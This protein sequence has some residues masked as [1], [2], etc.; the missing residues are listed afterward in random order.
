[1]GFNYKQD[2][3]NQRITH[4]LV[5]EWSGSVKPPCH[6]GS[7]Y[8]L[9]IAI[10]RLQEYQREST[11]P[12]TLLESK[13]FYNT[14]NRYY[15]NNLANSRLSLEKNDLLALRNYCKQT[16]AAF[17]PTNTALAGTFILSQYEE[18]LQTLENRTNQPAS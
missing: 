14:L 9:A 11:R 10:S 4:Q 15:R 12:R 1:M 13:K 17:D 18:L 7:A 3:Q 6:G 5:N 16:Q 2:R 8:P